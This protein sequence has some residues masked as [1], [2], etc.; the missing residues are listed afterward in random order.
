MDD[1]PT[2]GLPRVVHGEMTDILHWLENAAAAPSQSAAASLAHLVEALRTQIHPDD[3]PGVGELLRCWQSALHDLARRGAHLSPMDIPHMQRWFAGLHAHLGGT[4][5]PADVPGLVRMPTEVRWLPRLSPTFAHVILRRL[6]R[7]AGERPVGAPPDDPHGSAPAGLPMIGPPPDDAVP[8]PSPPALW[9][10]PDE[11]ELV[12]SA[13]LSQVLPL[14]QPW[15]DALV[16]GHEGDE[17]AD[18]IAQELGYQCELLGNALEL[19]GTPVLAAGNAALRDGIA[20]RDPA[21]DAECVARWSVT[22]LDALSRPGTDTADALADIAEVL[23]GLGPSWREGLREEL[24]RVVIGHDPALAH[25]RLRV[26]YIADV[27]LAPADDVLATVMEGMLRE[28]PGNAERLGASLRAIVSTRAPAAIDE[29]RRIAHTLKGDANTVGVRGLANL[30][31][32][33]EDILLVVARDPARLDADGEELLTSAGD[34]VEDIADH[35]LGRA[36]APDPEDL[37]ALYQRALDVANL[38]ADAPTEASAPD[39]ATPNA[40]AAP[41]IPASS[42]PPL[43][44]SQADNARALTVAS[45]LLDELQRLAGESLVTARQI[46]EQV[47]TLATVHREQRASLRATQDLIGRLD[48]L[49]ALR[50]A[51]LQSAALATGGELDPLEIDQYTELHVISRQLLEAHADGDEMMRRIDGVMAMLADLRSAQE[52]LNSD[53]QRTTLRTRTVPFG[54]VSPRLH[55]IVRQT[56]KLL[57]RDVALEVIG[58]EVP[59]DAETLERVVEPLAHLLRNAIDHG[60]EDPDER[61]ARGKPPSGRITVRVALQGDAAL[62]DVEDDGRGLDHDAILRRAIAAR[63]WRADQPVD[64]RQLERFVL[65]PGFST[66][67]AASETSGRG[68]G[69]DVVAQRVAALRG[70]LAL[71]STPGL[72]TRV[73]L[74]LPVTQTLANV[75]IARGQRQASA[76]V[77]SSV[78]RVV[79][80]GAGE[81]RLR[82]G[83][84]VVLV[85]GIDVQAWP[86]EAFHGERAD[87]TPWLSGEGVG[88]L[89]RD[90]LGAPHVVLVRRIDEVRPVVVKPLGAGLPPIPAVRGITQLGDGS[91]APVLDLDALLQSA[92]DA[93]IDASALAPPAVATA[94]VVVADDSLSVRRA[95]EQLMRDAGFDVATARDGLEALAEVQARPTSALLVD[96]EMP[97]MNGFELTRHLRTLEETRDLPV[98]MITSRASGKHLAMAEQ[99]GVTRILAKPVGEDALVQLVRG[100]VAG[101]G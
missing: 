49:V 34:G 6:L 73:Q 89:T 42:A 2:T 81:C 56:A 77:A 24:A 31:H 43:A 62:V 22:L 90:A 47:G 12:R 37:C 69:M 98:V 16:P 48:D 39:D 95:M 67:E 17:A 87:P 99:A 80:F 55:R 52:R 38:L 9:I 101:Q 78:E 3:A 10:G 75:I 11:L 29:A 100:L 65:L 46:D 83:G 58:G 8:D 76:L 64:V 66:R 1:T 94:R 27:S 72:G 40:A 25:A 23:P 92:L 84:L 28:L 4:L 36:P 54:Q 45:T 50:G 20:R 53:L 82:D 59:I 15:A 13:I 32:V 35:L 7:T 41:P 91:L 74:R 70:S 57:S 71:A 93:H 18:V 60:I 63:L 44:A 68:I 85:E 51:A 61:L 86:L 26:A 79:S 88:L 21:V 97:R 5:Q 14:A 30:T 96:L 33:L 19:L